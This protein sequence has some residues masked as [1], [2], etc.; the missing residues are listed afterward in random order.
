MPA[1]SSSSDGG[2]RSTVGSGT[3]FLDDGG[4]GGF[5]AGSDVPVLARTD[6]GVVGG[7]SYMVS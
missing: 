1:S 6:L 3:F 7:G 4:R 5:N 2:T